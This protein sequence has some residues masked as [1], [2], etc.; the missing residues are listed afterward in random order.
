[1]TH[2]LD[3]LY[4]DNYGMIILQL[5]PETS[6]A[7]SSCSRGRDRC[8]HFVIN[9]SESGK[10]LVC[11]DTTGHGTLSELIDYYRAKPIEP[12][13]EHLTSSCV[14]VRLKPRRAFFKETQEN[15]EM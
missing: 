6:L 10:F 8:R 5:P 4:Y 1:M 3:S 7:F 13:G 15:R 11:G 2:K 14:E 9:Q 12:F